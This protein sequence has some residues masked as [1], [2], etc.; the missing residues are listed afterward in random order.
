MRLILAPN[1]MKRIKE[2]LLKSQEHKIGRKYSKNHKKRKMG[3][4]LGD[5]IQSQRLAILMKIKHLQGVETNRIFSHSL[6]DWG[7]S[8]TISSLFSYN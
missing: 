6:E 4:T 8:L 3:C 2:K 1:S 5:E 7:E